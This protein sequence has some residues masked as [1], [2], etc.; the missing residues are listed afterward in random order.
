LLLAAEGV[1][2]IENACAAELYPNDVS[3][4]VMLKLYE[5]AAEESI[6]PLI[7]PVDTLS[8]SPGGR[9]PEAID[10]CRVAGL[11]PTAEKV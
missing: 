10:H 11:P 9:A 4:A 7:V 2:G 8:T 6:N 5:L 1:T 3:V